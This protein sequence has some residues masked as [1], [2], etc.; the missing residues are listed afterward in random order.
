VDTL[1]IAWVIALCRSGSLFLI[2]QLPSARR[3]P[4]PAR[5]LVAALLACLIAPVWEPMVAELVQGQAGGLSSFQLASFAW[6][7]ILTGLCFGL[8]W[9]GITEVY[10]FGM[11]M[12]SIQAGFSY[13][14]MIDPTSEADSGLLLVIGQF[15][16]LLALLSLGYHLEFLRSFLSVA[17]DFS[18]VLPISM[19][20][21]AEL[22]IHLL[23]EISLFALR[24][25]LPLI[26]FLVVVDIVFVLLGKFNEKLQL[27]SLSLGL[28]TLAA[29]LLLASC[30]PSLSSLSAVAARKIEQHW[31]REVVQ[32]VR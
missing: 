23:R 14:S 3:A 22:V 15:I 28:K 2:I 17:P 5:V 12:L 31:T 9:S 26:S 20:L 21:A 32:L 18:P 8:A 7:E 10:A 27:I 16:S 29:L 4:A 25:S 24:I 13:A 11:Q 30:L 1:A 19:G 6:R